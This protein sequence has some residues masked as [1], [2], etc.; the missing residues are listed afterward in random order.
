MTPEL[1]RR[2]RRTPQ[3]FREVLSIER[4]LGA[5]AERCRDCVNIADRRELRA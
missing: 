3:P 4:K 2:Y 1:R 5:A